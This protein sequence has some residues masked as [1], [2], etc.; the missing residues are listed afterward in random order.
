MV[1]VREEMNTVDHV[2]DWLVKC[3]SP[4]PPPLSRRDVSEKCELERQ[5]FLEEQVRP[6]HGIMLVHA[7]KSAG[8]RTRT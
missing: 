6:E 1:F 8:P 4:L 3:G 7:D 5:V 2:T